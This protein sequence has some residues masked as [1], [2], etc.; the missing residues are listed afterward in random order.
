MS[1]K[2]SAFT[3][4]ELLVV[5]SIIALLIG[6]LLP[7]LGAARNT[8][9]DLKCLANQRQMGIGFHAYASEYDQILPPAFDNQNYNGQPQTGRYSL[10]RI[11]KGMPTSPSMI[12]SSAT[13]CSPAHKRRCP[14]AG[15]TTEPTG[16]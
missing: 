4:I 12:W 10:P 1:R 13:S 8:A 6:I 14:K 3:L 15:C 16:M 9:R 7:A 5:I 2:T 11:W